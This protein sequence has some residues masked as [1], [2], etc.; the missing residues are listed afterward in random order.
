[1]GD[2]EVLFLYTDGLTEGKDRAGRMFGLDRVKRLLGNLPFT[3]DDLMTPEEILQY[4]VKAAHDF[5]DGTEQS[6]DLT[7]LVVQHLPKSQK[8]EEHLVLQN[9]LGELARLKQFVVTVADKTGME[10]TVAHNVRL[11]LEEV[12]VN[13]MEYAYP[14][15]EGEIR[16]DALFDNRQLTLVVT[17]SGS[18]FDP[19]AAEDADTTLTAEERPIGG[20]GIF[21]TRQLMDTVD[22]ERKDGKNVLTMKKQLL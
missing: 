15:Q 22:Y 14:G 13:V 6:D 8:G 12:V 3:T 2:G 20:L 1:M 16:V 19:T 11:A 18:P 17:D 10:A 4:M 9:N 7:M 21:L 5:A